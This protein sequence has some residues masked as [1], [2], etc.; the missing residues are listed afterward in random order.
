MSTQK[1]FLRDVD[2]LIHKHAR[3]SVHR[4]PEHERTRFSYTTNRI[5]ALELIEDLE[6]Q[7]G[8]FSA[9]ITY[10]PFVEEKWQVVII[11]SFGKGTSKRTIAIYDDLCLAICAAVLSRKNINIPEE[12]EK[13]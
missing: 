12:P 13:P 8:F 1:Q 5:H 11:E 3:P 4:T 6:Y 7:P 10:N 9:E 2:E